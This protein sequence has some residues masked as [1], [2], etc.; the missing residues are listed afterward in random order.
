V[1]RFANRRNEAIAA[2]RHGQDKTPLVRAFAERLAQRRDVDGQVA[3]FHDGVG[4]EQ[5]DQLVFLQHLPAPFDQGQQQINRF[6]RQRHN[7]AVTQ[8]YTPARV[9]AEGAEFINTG[10][11]SFD[12]RF[13]KSWKI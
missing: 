13:W 9:Q 7:L 10:W 11:V 12:H 2:P 6:G 1:A 3:F 4:P 5:P 8:Q